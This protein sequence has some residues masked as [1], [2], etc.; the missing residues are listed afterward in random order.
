[1]KRLLTIVAFIFS[2]MFV[3]AQ[4][5]NN[6]LTFKGIP[7][8]GTLESFAQKLEAKGFE[9][10]YSDKTS[11]EFEGEFAGYSDSEIY[12]SR[13]LD[14][15]IVYRVVV[16]FPKKSSWARLEEQYNKFKDMLT[17]KYGKPASHSETFKKRASTFS[18]AA[19]MRS[20]KA[21]N[22]DYE[23]EWKVDNGTIT[24]DIFSLSETDGVYVSLIYFDK[25]NDAL[26]DKAIEDDL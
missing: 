11:V 24:V 16:V 14:R 8:T 6:H 1:M 7:I 9:K 12:V 25:I 22:C 26:A 18:D 21:G 3:M 4:T 2:F 15:N 17:N 5:P 23:A 10:K 19:K 20:L 13:D